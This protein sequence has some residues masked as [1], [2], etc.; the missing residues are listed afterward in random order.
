MLELSL[1]DGGELR[2]CERELLARLVSAHGAAARR[3]TQLAA[4]KAE[5][6]RAADEARKHDKL[7]EQHEEAHAVQQ[8]ALDTADELRPVLEEAQPAAAAFAAL[9]AS[10]RK[11]TCAVL[12]T[13]FSAPA[14]FSE[15][16]AACSSS[17]RGRYTR[18]P[19]HWHP[20]S[21]YAFF[22][23]FASCAKCAGRPTPAPPDAPAA[24]AAEPAS[25]CSC[26]PGP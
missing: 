17:F 5:S 24:A 3:S 15:S 8:A 16:A 26:A 12:V 11:A 21:K 22:A 7:R 25:P 13:V 10:L 6:T 1:A 20:S 14:G 19:T 9:A 2:A 23:R 18:R 4:A